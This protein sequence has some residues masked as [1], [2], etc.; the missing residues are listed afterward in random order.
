MLEK[1]YVV[2]YYGAIEKCF[3][4]EHIL[5]GRVDICFSK[6]SSDFLVKIVTSI[7]LGLKNIHKHLI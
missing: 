4:V 3:P 5:V 1:C 6:Y 7:N 2:M